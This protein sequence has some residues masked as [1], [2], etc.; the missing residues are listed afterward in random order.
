VDFAPKGV[1]FY[2]IYKALAHPETNRFVTPFT[3]E[4]RLMHVAEAKKRLGSQISWLCDSM[5]ND[6]KHTLGDAPNSE[7]IVGPDGKLVSVRQWSSPAE[8]RKDLA[9][10]VGD[11]ASP[12][13]VADL[14]LPQMSPPKSAPTGIVPR[15]QT[16][17]RMSPLIV[18][19]LGLSKPNAQPFYAKLRAEADQGLLTSGQG[20]LYLGFFLDPL[21]EVHWNNEAAPVRIE[22]HAP[23]G[24]TLNKDYFEAPEIEVPADADPREFL[25]DV[26]GGDARPLRLTVWYFACD[27]A[28]TFCKPVK[29]EYEI[30]LQRDRDGGN[31]RTARPGSNNRRSPQ[32]D[33]NRA[34]ML[35]RLPLIRVLDTDAD[36]EISAE[37][38]SRATDSLLKMDA[39]GDGSLSPFELR[40]AP[41]R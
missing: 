13:T 4:E 25:V 26:S 22:I 6:L 5:E 23:E 15:V 7:F 12:T 10:L 8:L 20:M 11:V 31:R 33:A 38:M 2:Y 24:V 34:R 18:T 41:I 36:G 37:E 35:Q 32:L 27:D 29:Q 39:N 16:P 21:Y 28:E 3:L 9:A 19:P 14:N 1:R 17:G 40:R 30:T